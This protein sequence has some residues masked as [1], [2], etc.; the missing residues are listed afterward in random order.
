[1]GEEAVVEVA[2][3]PQ[4]H[5]GRVGPVGPVG[6]VVEQAVLKE[7]AEEAAPLDECLYHSAFL[8]GVAP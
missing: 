2:S 7:G 8:A 1:M 6:P 3:V 5:Y 4:L